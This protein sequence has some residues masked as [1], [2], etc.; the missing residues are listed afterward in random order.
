ENRM[1]DRRRQKDGP[2]VGKGKMRSPPMEA[3]PVPMRVRIVRPGI[4]KPPESVKGMR[5]ERVVHVSAR[6]PRDVARPRPP[7]PLEILQAALAH[8]QGRCQAVVD[9][10]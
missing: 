4:A 10:L 1:I 5:G 9:V 7:A 3:P 6:T 2:A 8:N